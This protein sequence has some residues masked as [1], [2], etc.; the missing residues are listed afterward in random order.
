MRIY[1]SG[2]IL[3]RD[4]FCVMLQLLSSFGKQTSLAD[5]END[6]ELQ[7]FVAE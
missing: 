2:P 3:Q 5:D 7:K 4:R 6:V 1:E